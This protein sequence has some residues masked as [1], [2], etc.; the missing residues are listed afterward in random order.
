M[1]PSPPLSSSSKTWERRLSEAKRKHRPKL[2]HWSKDGF[3][4]HHHRGHE[5]QQL[6]H[7]SLQNHVNHVR[8][9]RDPLLPVPTQLIAIDKIS[10]H[11]MT[12]SQFMTSYE[13][14][15]LPC[16]I[17]GVPQQQQWP[18]QQNWTLEQLQKRKGDNDIGSRLFKVGE[19][20]YHSSLWAGCLP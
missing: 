5:F 18:A 9:P 4:I 10:C 3:H 17:S 8:Q 6:R 14:K 19:G 2:Q 13:M 16:I 1:T 7:E 15:N 20:R 12:P 11:H